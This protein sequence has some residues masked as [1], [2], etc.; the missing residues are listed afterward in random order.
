MT[1][2][3]T[4]KIYPFPIRPRA[5]KAVQRDGQRKVAEIGSGRL[6]QTDFGSG[7]YHD[8][9]IKDEPALKRS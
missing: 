8:A 7:W 5:T 1:E 2:T 3:G 4:A 6:P 9:A